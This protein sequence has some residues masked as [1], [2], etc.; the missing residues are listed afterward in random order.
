MGSMDFTN[1]NMNVGFF[2]WILSM[3]SPKFFCTRTDH[4]VLP[5][6]VPTGNPLTPH[7]LTCKPPSEV[8]EKACYLT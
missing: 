3:E 5:P 1:M 8:R 4:Y 6:T 7:Y 2:S